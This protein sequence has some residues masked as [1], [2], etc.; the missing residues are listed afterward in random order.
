M[1]LTS[2]ITGI[3]PSPPCTRDWQWLARKPALRPCF[4]HKRLPRGQ[5]DTRIRASA[6][7]EHR[8][9]IDLPG[10]RYLRAFV[11]WFETARSRFLLPVRITQRR[12]YSHT[13]DLG[14]YAGALTAS[15]RVGRRANGWAGWVSVSI[16]A[17][18]KGHAIDTVFDLDLKM[19]HASNGHA[20][21]EC[22]PEYA[23]SYPSRE[24]LWIEHN[25]EA[26]LAFVNDQMAKA[27][28]LNLYVTDGGSSWAAFSKGPPERSGD[29][30]IACIARDG[31]IQYERESRHCDC[32]D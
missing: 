19:T 4:P 18:W 16:L 3:P 28:T 30:L 14:A 6:N 10:S 27:E 26:L 31:R 25:F 2:D 23:K 17:N 7:P 20:C 32:S 24:A 5:R 21:G 29:N 11:R 12:R 9:L 8:I 1:Y 13:L 22:L 15:I